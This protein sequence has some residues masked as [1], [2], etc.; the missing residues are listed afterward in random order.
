MALNHFGVHIT[1]KDC[2]K[3]AKNAKNVIFLIA[4]F[5]RQ[6]NE[7]DGVGAI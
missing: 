6:A 4:H 1:F 7:E 2:F 3:S 5:G